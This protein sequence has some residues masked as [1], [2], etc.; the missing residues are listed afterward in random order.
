MSRFRRKKFGR[1][2]GG[3]GFTGG[4][5]WFGFVAIVLGCVS[6]IVAFLMFGIAIDQLDDAYT[7]VAGY[8]EAVGLQSV[9]GMWGMVLFLVFALIGLAGIVGGAVSNTLSGLKGNWMGIM[10]GIIM[11]GVTIAIAVI[12][13][14]LIQS[15]LH[16]AWVTANATVNKASFVGM[17]DIMG[18]FGMVY[19]ISLMIAGVAPI[20]GGIVGGY[21]KVRGGT[22]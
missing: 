13:N 12:M 16:A 20:V 18:I 8:T 19:F 3:S 9:M 15:Q 1:G 7:A 14:G 21:R 5:S 17:L 11:G 2:G 22:F 10:M 4:K 6:A